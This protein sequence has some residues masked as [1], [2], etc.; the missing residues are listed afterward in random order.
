MK[1]KCPVCDINYMPEPGFYYG[2]MFISYGIWAWFSVLLCLA[3]VFYLEWTV[4][5]AFALLLV[6]SAILYVPLFRISRSIWAHINI[7]YR[8]DFKD[9]KSKPLSD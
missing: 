8:A 4:N 1:A 7:K 5:S 3:L 9:K 2:S 6:I